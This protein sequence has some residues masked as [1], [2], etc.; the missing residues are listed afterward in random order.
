MRC[1]PGLAPRGREDHGG[2]GDVLDNA[3]R[4]R[5]DGHRLQREQITVDY[6]DGIQAG[7]QAERRAA[8]GR[9]AQLRKLIPGVLIKVTRVASMSVLGDRNHQTLYCGQDF[10]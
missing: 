10:T 4:G 6:A 1:A 2:V 5:A 8:D 3:R 9:Q 7:V